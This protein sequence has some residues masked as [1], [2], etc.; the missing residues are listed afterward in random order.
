[1]RWILFNSRNNFERSPVTKNNSI[2]HELL[3]C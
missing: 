3:Y 1:L 2:K